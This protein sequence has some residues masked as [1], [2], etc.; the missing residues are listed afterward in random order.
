MTAPTTNS[1]KEV[2][3]TVALVLS[4]LGI[5][6]S[7]LSSIPGVI[8]GHISLNRKKDLSSS[9]KGLAI[10]SLCVGY[11]SIALW[12]LVLTPFLFTIGAPVGLQK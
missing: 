1:R 8:C 5:F 4:C 7:P 3:P 2:L 10:A 9:A 11:G 12:V 6:L